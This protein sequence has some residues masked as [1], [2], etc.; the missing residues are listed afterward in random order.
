M[1]EWLLPA[2]VAIA[3]LA[4]TYLFCLRPMRRGHRS[5]GASP[6]CVN[7]SQA[8]SAQAEVAELDWALSQAR[9]DLAR[10]RVGSGGSS[11]AQAHT[12]K[13]AAVPLPDDDAA[14]R[15]SAQHGE[16]RRG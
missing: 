12:D 1:S 3:S 5:A 13:P 4:L 9:A 8:G 10:L 16:G 2:G 15:A 6:A 7:H 11:A 14:R